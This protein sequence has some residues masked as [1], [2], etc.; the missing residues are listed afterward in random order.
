MH[1][2][3]EWPE[4]VSTGSQNGALLYGVEY[5]NTGAVDK[6]HNKDAGCA[7]CE[8]KRSTGMPY[9]QWGRKTCSNGHKTEYHGLV[10]AD[11]Y[12]HQKSEYIC[13]DWE[14][15][16]HKTSSNADQNGSLLY[17]TEMEAKGG[18]AD[19]IVY[20]QDRELSCALCS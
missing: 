6:N 4:G 7:V 14:R 18:S 10:M 9:V 16:A 20:G 8:H 2:E 13:V 5:E 1:P 12:T 15:A 19:E 17:T 11:H 3:P